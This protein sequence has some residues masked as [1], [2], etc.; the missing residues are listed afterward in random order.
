MAKLGLVLAG[1]VGGLLMAAGVVAL[2]WKEFDSATTEV[3]KASTELMLENGAIIPAGT[4][5]TVD[6]YMPEGFVRLS[7]AINAEGESLG[8]FDM[9]TEDARNLSLPYWVEQ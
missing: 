4:E 6:K 5:M 3:W 1:F 9:R 7:L 2:V 8:Q